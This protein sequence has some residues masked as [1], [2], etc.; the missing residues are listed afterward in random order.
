MDTGLAGK[1]VLVTGGS[2]GI[3]GACVRA[4]MAEGARVV[5]PR[6]SGQTASS[7]PT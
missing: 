6:R 5:G 7:R 3:G 4:F 1:S 2:G